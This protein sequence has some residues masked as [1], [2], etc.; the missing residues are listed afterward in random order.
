MSDKRIDI[1][2]LV[3]DGFPARMVLQSE[4]LPK[5]VEEGKRVAIIVPN[6]E[7]EGVKTIAKRVG[8]ELIQYETVNKWYLDDYYI[9]KRYLF[10]DF[11]KN[12]TL[13]EKHIRSYKE[14][15]KNKHPWRIVRPLVF[16]FIYYLRLIFPFI[17]KWVKKRENKFLRSA[18]VNSLLKRIDPRLLVVTYPSDMTESVYLKEAKALKIPTAIQLLSWDNITAK[19]FF[20]EIGDYFI[21]WGR[22][23]SDE[24]VEYYNFPRDK[25]YETGVAHFDKHINEVKP[26]LKKQY[27]SE[28]KLDCSKP[29]LFFGMSSPYFAPY[30][31]EIVEWLAKQI[32]A[33]KFGKDVQLLVRPHPQNV[34]GSMADTSWLPR[35]DALVSKKVKIDYPIIDKKSVM[36]WSMKSEDLFKMVNLLGSSSIVLNSGST[37]SIDGLMQKKPVI[38][39]PF[40]ADAYPKWYISAR[41]MKDFLHLKK[42]TS[43]GGVVVVNNFKELKEAINKFIENP[44]HLLA[45]REEAK[46]AECGESDGKASERIANALI[47]ILNKI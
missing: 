35:L 16:S 30:E 44:N 26:E 13:L 29:I 15:F 10:E 14:M 9:L 21:S 42:L 45:E 17:P 47:D 2:Y 12:A 25:I 38:M 5:L 41:K 1:A 46:I 34:T 43:S 24:F 40:D 31:I 11:K 20:S 8:V 4:T 39:T 33:D 18:E 22:I 28:Y 32:D 36:N 19:G 7:E 27:V 6:P 23:M 3:K 37:L